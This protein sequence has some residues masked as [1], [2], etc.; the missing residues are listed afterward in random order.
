MAGTRGTGL[1]P[2]GSSIIPSGGIALVQYKTGTTADGSAG[3]VVP[4]GAAVVAGAGTSAANGTY[5][6]SGNYLNGRPYFNISGTTGDVSS[7]YWNGAQW[8]ISSSGGATLYNSSDNV[9]LPWLATF[10]VASG[11]AN[12]PTVTCSSPVT[13]GNA[14]IDAVSWVNE[15]V[16]LAQ[17][18]TL[19]GGGA[20]MLS[21]VVGQGG[22][23]GAFVAHL[24]KKTNVAG[25]ETG[26]VYAP[27]DAVR[28]N[29]IAL[30]VS[31]LADAAASDTQT[32]SGNGSVAVL[33]ADLAGTGFCIFA[34]SAA[35]ATNPFTDIM[36]N[37]TVSGAGTSAANG[38][39][40]YNGQFGGKSKYLLP[41][42]NVGEIKWVSDGDPLPYW[43]IR[44]DNGI[45][46]IS[47]ADTPTPSGQT[48][49][50]LDGDS[51][52]PTVTEL[53]SEW[54]HLATVGG[55]SNW[56]YVAKKIGT[57][58]SVVVGMDSALDYATV[59]AVFE[60]E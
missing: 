20:S 13:A 11:A 41:D 25:G 34:A 39:Y 54:Q 49:T 3:L 19:I 8:R 12:A 23:S 24:F 28:A 18:P 60:G 59:G 14:V 35:N 4:F 6:F 45:F 10:A 40:V 53:A 2:S 58:T 47:V 46:Y 56:L 52:V 57:A 31:G 37:M 36:S 9:S 55:A 22:G 42:S 7:V 27:D 29:Q 17:D 26:I 38:T 21:D 51:P 48:F 1:S 16:P 50:Q 33:S 15:A 32:G 5:A 43:A 44:D 30:E